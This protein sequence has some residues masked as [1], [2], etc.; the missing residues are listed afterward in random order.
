M[1]RASRENMRLMNLVR[2]IGVGTFTLICS[3]FV[4]LGRENWRPIASGL[5]VYF[6]LAALVWLVA[7]TKDSYLDHSRLGISVIDIPMV[8]VIQLRGL[9]VSSSPGHIS[10]FSISVFICLVMLSAMTLRTPLVYWAIGLSLIGE[11]IIQ[12][13]AEIGLPGRLVS[14]LIMLIATWIC[15]H[16]GRKR[17]SLVKDVAGAQAKRRRLQR[18]F[19]PGIGEMIEDLEGGELE[20]GKE[21]ELTIIVTDI[22]G[23]TRL[24]EELGCKETVALL[25]SVH[26]R[27]VETLFRHAGTLDKYMGDG[28]LAYFNAPIGQ[29]DHAF[30]AVCC[31]LDMQKALADLNGH[32][33]H[34][35]RVGIGIH[36]GRA[37]VGNIGAPNR[38]EFTA[39]GDAVNVTS[40]IET[41]T[42]ELDC[43]LLLS[44]TTCALIENEFPL[45]PMGSFKVRGRARELQLFTIDSN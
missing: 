2:F 16:A 1:Q 36:T 37:V 30:R 9:E 29:E 45:K 24:S 32:H 17:I 12:A 7:R 20:Q 41:L 28:L 35:L 6:V 11:Q 4:M 19:S 13:E 27:M 33:S 15:L 31:A 43:E 25:N 44:Q 40:R 3:T 8:T 39:I 21:C 42:K 23:F 26:S 34:N 38:R 22:R 14:A 10:E 18:Y 5:A